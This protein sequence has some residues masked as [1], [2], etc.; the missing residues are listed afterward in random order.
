MGVVGW[1]RHGLFSLNV[2]ANTSATANTSNTTMQFHSTGAENITNAPEG[3]PRFKQLID[4]KDTAATA[5]M[6]IR[7]LE[8]WAS[9]EA[10]VRAFATGAARVLL[11]EVVVASDIVPCAPL[12]L[13]EAGPVLA[14]PI[15]PA[16]GA[17]DEFA[18]LRRLLALEALTLA[19]SVAGVVGGGFLA[20]AQL[21]LETLAS[22]RVV[23]K[24]KKAVGKAV[25]AALLSTPELRGGVKVEALKKRRA[26]GASS[27]ADAVA[28]AARFV[29]VLRLNKD[30]LHAKGLT[31][32]TVD[33]AVRR[34]LA[35]DATVVA[36]DP[37]HAAWVLMFRPLDVPGRVG[38]PAAVWD[39]LADRD[40]ATIERAV[41]E[42]MHDA[43]IEALV[44]H[45]HPAITQAV[46]RAEAR[47][48]VNART[49][50]LEVAATWVVDTE[51][52]DLR[53]VAL[54]P[55]VDIRNTVTNNVREV[56]RVL[57][58]EATADILH[59]QLHA[60]ICTSG[61]YVDP[62][63]MR[64]MALVMCR[65]G[66]FMP[67]NRH[68]LKKMG[69]AGL[70]QMASYEQA[71][72]VFEH[73][74]L[75]GEKDPL[76]G[77]IEK[78]I[79]GQPFNVGTGAF[80]VRAVAIHLPEPEAFVAPL[81]MEGGGTAKT[82]VA[83]ALVERAAKRAAK[84]TIDM[85]AV[86]DAG[87]A[88]D[89]TDDNDAEDAGVAP[90]RYRHIEALLPASIDVSEPKRPAKHEHGGKKVDDGAG[91]DGEGVAPLKPRT[92][93]AALVYEPA[94][95][96][97]A[98]PVPSELAAAVASVAA[99]ASQ[100]RDA[101]KYSTLLELEARLGHL[102]AA[103]RF[104]PGVPA[105]AFRRIE[106]A[107]EAYK[108]WTDA[109]PLVVVD[110]TAGAATVWQ[111][112]TH[113]VYDL[114]DGT[115]ARTISAWNL[116]HEGVIAKTHVCKTELAR[117]DLAVVTVA[118]EALNGLAVRAALH[119]EE[120]IHT[121]RLPARVR[122]KWVGIKQR[123]VYQ[124]GAWT[125]TLTRVWGGATN[126]EAE[127][128]QVTSLR[129]LSG[130]KANAKD[131][132][133][134]EVEVELTA[135]GEILEHRSATDASIAHALLARMHDFT[136]EGSAL[137]PLA[138]ADGAGGDADVD[139]D[140]DAAASADSDGEDAEREGEGEGVAPLS[141]EDE[142]DDA[143]EGVAPLMSSDEEEAEEDETNFT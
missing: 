22:D 41:T 62:R 79:V 116:A 34:V 13:A 16:A 4:A 52:S 32:A 115:E 143:E 50:A 95:P 56:N 43:L 103:G 18:G 93:R 138:A 105:A 14:A 2:N 26:A 128:A 15:A 73:G 119:V 75:F 111:Q 126:V 47:H 92:A 9:S 87:D 23:S 49:G 134:Y 27:G 117:V 71:K 108:G 124:K 3:L 102:T 97:P 112:C 64:M 142:E 17:A 100:V 80:D 36:A 83:A 39:G 86:G 38:M 24:V 42:A 66:V 19:T 114:E 122:P 37:L 135:P 106:V 107:L 123:K 82:D 141:N 85:V 6:T 81:G 7:F 84:R 54:L 91:D 68:K 53:S 58:I 11:S 5:K 125:F 74:A 140:A 88:G 51:G 113:D 118:G 57:G 33:G 28:S 25:E 89:A 110:G 10:R 8:P 104:A 44:V 94:N 120:A 12:S 69:V 109:P 131:V 48:V 40:R 127:A 96:A 31:V 136:G 63:H 76:V 29:A 35:G 90:L 139:V 59:Q 1:Q 78:M 55:G 99:L 70:L 130:G 98:A 121:S 77:P 46:A 21:E 61:P 72:E 129:H 132:T 67:L 101:A 133:V 30:A 137:V 65:G 45:G 20:A 60:V